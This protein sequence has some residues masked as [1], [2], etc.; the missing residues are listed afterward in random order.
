MAR[1]L[2]LGF[3]PESLPEV[4]GFEVGLLYEP[5]ASQPTGGDV[6]GAWRDPVGRAWPC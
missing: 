3:V 6:Y 4:P 2:T 1:A 5:A